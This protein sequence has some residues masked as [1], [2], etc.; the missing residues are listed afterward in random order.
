MTATPPQLTAVAELVDRRV[1]AFLA[2][3]HKR[4]EAV[5][6]RMAELVEILT[7]AF[8][9]G[10]KRLRAGFCY[11]SWVGAMGQDDPGFDPQ[12]QSELLQPVIDLCAAIELL[13][14]FALIHD[15]VMDDSD[16]RR[17]FPAVHVEQASRTGPS[18]WRGE[19][20]RFGE[21]V[22]VLAGNLGHVYADRLVSQSPEAVRLLWN[23]MKVELNIGQYFDV[24]S[25]VAGELDAQTARQVAW[26]K[27]ALY[28]IRRP[29]QLGLAASG[30]ASTSDSAIAD[31]FS[32]PLGRAFQL[33][34]DLLGLFGDPDRLGKPTGDDIRA[35]KSTEILAFA[36]QKA[37]PAQQQTLDT[38]MT[39]PV[40]SGDIETVVEVI[41]AT[42]A[43]SYVEQ[44]I[45]SLVRS[46][47]IVL[48][49]MPLSVGAC[50]ALLVLARFV[51][52]RDV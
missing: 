24:R 40:R 32:E 45:E 50:E 41:R 38:A 28:T 33:R 25:S 20:R 18:G 44:E 51:A 27:S 8:G 48:D 15:D 13:H 36:R 26:F 10:G 35:S 19:P 14:V 39:S 42:G 52:T 46:A 1:H 21:S 6:P 2:A 22:A 30:R 43:V 37:T 9:R 16:Q 49:E 3:E 5:D 34:D 12:H 47:E 4:W 31:A 23:D 29:L 7:A 11:W 17:G